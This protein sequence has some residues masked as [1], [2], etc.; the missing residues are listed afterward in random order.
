MKIVN[1]HQRL[2]HAAPER[3]SALLAMLGSPADQVWPPGGVD[4]Q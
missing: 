4:P 3:V 1:V 2:L